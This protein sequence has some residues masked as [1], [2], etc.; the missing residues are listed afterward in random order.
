MPFVLII[1]GGLLIITGYHGNQSQLFGIIRDEFTTKP[2][3]PSFIWWIIS[4]MI[5]GSLGYIPGIKK[6]SDAF[7]L[8]ILTDL[9][10]AKSSNMSDWIL[11]FE[12]A[13]SDS[14]K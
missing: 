4:I 6:L 13:I 7:L 14:S 8:L 5:V 3:A 9:V 10:F 1:I 11:K 2:N 12:K